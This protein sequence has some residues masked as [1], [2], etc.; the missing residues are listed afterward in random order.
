[1]KLIPIKYLLADGTE[2]PA[3]T[4]VKQCCVCNRKFA[5]PS[6]EL[7][8]DDVCCEDCEGEYNKKEAA[9]AIVVMKTSDSDA[10]AT[11]NAALGN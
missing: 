6:S 10:N 7:N 5:V 1:M 11:I 9:D 2:A 8:N 3:D 4:V